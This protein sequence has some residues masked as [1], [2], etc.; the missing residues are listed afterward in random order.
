MPKKKKADAAPEMDAN[1]HYNHGLGR[2]KEIQAPLLAM[3]LDAKAKKVA[4]EAETSLKTA[5]KLADNHG[6]AHI[7]LGMLYRYTGKPKDALPHLKRGMELPPDSADWLKACES[8]G[9]C[10]ML[11]NDGKGAI[12]VFRQGLLNHPMESM[13]HY[14]IGACLVDEGDTEGAKLALQSALG[15]DPNYADA[16]KL[17]DTLGG[18]PPPPPGPAA[19]IDY[20]AAGAEAERLGKELQEAMM[21]LMAGKGKPEDKTTKAMKLQDEFQKKIKALYGS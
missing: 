18:A 12:D 11:L 5:L 21:K 14:K 20:A 6:R 2:M 17:L 7:M 10:L 16:K 19:D 1:D 3:K 8:L 9:S 13:L 4:G 15:L